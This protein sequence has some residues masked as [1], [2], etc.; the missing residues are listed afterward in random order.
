MGKGR[1]HLLL[2][3]LPSLC[4]GDSGY[5]A[6]QGT[7]YNSYDSYSA[8]SNNHQHSSSYSSS[9]NSN[10]NGNSYNSDYAYPVHQDTINIVHQSPPAVVQHENVNVHH[11]F[12]HQ[13]QPVVN[14]PVPPQ[15]HI[16]QVPQNVPVQFVPVNV[17]TPPPQFQ[18]VPVQYAPGYGYQLPPANQCYDYDLECLAAVGRDFG[19]PIGGGGGGYPGAGGYGGYPGG[20]GYG[21]YPPAGGFGGNS[22]YVQRKELVKGALLLG[23]GIVKGALITTLVQSAVN[24]NGKK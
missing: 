4:L 7:P 24:N 9:G 12:Y 10:Y 2:V 1:P 17:P 16:V 11:H 3:F 6:P 20:G 13:A 22:P 18:Q 19:L 23:A 8:P 21:G 15:P 5:G 14:V